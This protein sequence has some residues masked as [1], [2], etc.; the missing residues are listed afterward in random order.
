MIWS[1]FLPLIDT[2]C[3]HVCCW[4]STNNQRFIIHHI[5]YSQSPCRLAIHL[6]NRI[7]TWT[8]TCTKKPRMTRKIVKK[9]TNIYVMMNKNQSLTLTHQKVKESMIIPIYLKNAQGMLIICT[10]ILFLITKLQTQEQC[11]F[12]SFASKQS[13]PPIFHFG[14]STVLIWLKSQ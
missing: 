13:I 7:Q 8:I 5:N 12:L 10:G 3:M 9:C 6:Y 4:L 14:A 11:T 2:K 1:V